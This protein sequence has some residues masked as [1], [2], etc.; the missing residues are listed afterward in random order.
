MLT[1][2]LLCQPGVDGIVLAPFVYEWTTLN[3]KLGIE[4]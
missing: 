2:D 3:S 1:T 4:M